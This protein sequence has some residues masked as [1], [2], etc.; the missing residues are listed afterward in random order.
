MCLCFHPGG[1]IRPS[2]LFAAEV[3]QPRRPQVDHDACQPR[4]AH[5]HLPG[6]PCRMH[7]GMAVI[8]TP[9]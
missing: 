5:P 9:T 1:Q 4:I 2:G 3:P 8:R 7:R 6:A